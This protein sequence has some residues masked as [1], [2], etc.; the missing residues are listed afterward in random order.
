MGIRKI[1]MLSVFITYATNEW[2]RLKEM[3]KALYIGVNG[4]DECR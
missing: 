4:I 2:E 1:I 3:I